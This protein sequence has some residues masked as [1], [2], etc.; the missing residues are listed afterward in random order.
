MSL[1]RNSKRS[2]SRP[3]NSRSLCNAITASH[4]WSNGNKVIFPAGYTR[5]CS[6]C[7]TCRESG[8]PKPECDDESVR[9]SSCDP[10]K[11]NHQQIQLLTAGYTRIHSQASIPLDIIQICTKYIDATTRIVIRGEELNRFRE[12]GMNECFNQY[13]VKYD[14]NIK[15]SLK[16]SPKCKSKRQSD[17]HSG[18]IILRVCCRTKT[19]KISNVSYKLQIGLVETGL[20]WTTAGILGQKVYVL[21]NTL[22]G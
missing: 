13:K 19:R 10:S 11:M 4:D 22:I 9:S 5:S 16:L 20:K 6:P 12:M 18:T 1:F 7:I 21:S 17:D 8:S 14:R 15:F 2:R 3:S